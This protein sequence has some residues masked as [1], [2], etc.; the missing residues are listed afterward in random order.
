[1]NL[2]GRGEKQKSLSFK[3]ERQGK[4]F[5]FANPCQSMLK[6]HNKSTIACV[7]KDGVISHLSNCNEKMIANF[8]PLVKSYYFSR[9]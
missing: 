6:S 2:N 7:S 1:M 4:C 5:F 3:R 9:Q 8:A